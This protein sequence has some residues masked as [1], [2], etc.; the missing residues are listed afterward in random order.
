MQNCLE[1]PALS[2]NKCKKGACVIFCLLLVCAL[3][4][5]CSM[6]GSDASEEKSLEIVYSLD[7]QTYRGG[8]TIQV[9]VVAINIGSDMSYY[10][11]I[12]YSGEVY[13]ET[14]NEIIAKDQLIYSNGESS[15]RILEKGTAY[16]TCLFFD[17]PQEVNPGRYD[18][19]IQIDT[20]IVLFSGVIEIVE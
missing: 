9:N 15:E 18:L 6:S 13:S 3:V 12:F 2:F 14:T 1:H 7:Q 17:L 10:G 20:Q 4:T 11:Q 19:R 5:G 8:E 16:E